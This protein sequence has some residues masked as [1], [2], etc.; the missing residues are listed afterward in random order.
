MTG[1]QPNMEGY[2]VVCAPRCCQ[3][4]DRQLQAV[5]YL[6]VETGVPVRQAVV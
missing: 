4:L 6:G 1:L 2:K 5:I 3:L